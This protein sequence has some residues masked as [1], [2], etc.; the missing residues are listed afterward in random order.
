MHRHERRDRLRLENETELSLQ[1]LTMTGLVVVVQRQS[2]DISNGYFEKLRQIVTASV[3]KTWLLVR[4]ENFIVC[5]PVCS[6]S[7]STLISRSKNV[8][9]AR[10]AERVPPVR[11]E[12]NHN[13]KR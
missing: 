12:A 8:V 7:I 3:S 10:L 2:L 1:T 4:P 13:G 9:P 6:H 5:L 11:C